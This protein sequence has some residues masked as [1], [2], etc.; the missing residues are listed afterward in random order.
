ME[1]E[2]RA[3]HR[4]HP[5]RSSQ[6]GGEY[7]YSTLLESKA[8]RELS[9][10]RDQSEYAQR[11]LKETTMSRKMAVAWSKDS[12]WSRVVAFHPAIAIT[13]SHTSQRTTSA[14]NREASK[15]T[16]S[17][18]AFAPYQFFHAM[19]ECEGLV[20]TAIKIAETAYIQRHLVK[21]P[22]DVMVCYDAT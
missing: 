22:Q 19:T 8:E 21:A 6:G 3:G 4:R 9:F 7:K 20:D 5:T 13:L 14:L 11:G 15:R 16:P 1:T 10:A 17:W 18:V 12:R 2:C